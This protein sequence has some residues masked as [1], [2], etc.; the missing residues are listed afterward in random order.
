MWLLDKVKHRT[1]WRVTGT[2]F[3]VHTRS[4]AVALTFDDGPDRR[5]T[6]TLLDCLADHRARASFFMVGEC[7]ARHPAIVERAHK[8]GHDTGN[9]SW[10]HP[11]LARVRFGETREQILKAEQAIRYNEHRLFRPPFGHQSASSFLAAKSLGL[12]IVSW[13]VIAMDWLD[14]DAETLVG[15]IEPKLGPGSIV[16]MHDHLHD[17]IE[18]RYLDRAP[19]VEAVERLLERLGTTFEFVPVSELLR[20]GRTIKQPWFERGQDDFLAKLTLTTE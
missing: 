10:S 14:D 7:A 19:T 16:L 3:S 20:R 8:A 17:Y 11:S 18:E 13:N 2:I 9:H 1:L 6:P 4:P 12:R 15:R 5:F